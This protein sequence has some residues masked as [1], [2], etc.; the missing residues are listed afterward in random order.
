[1]HVWGLEKH[2]RGLGVRPA[3]RL[4]E[5]GWVLDV[6]VGVLEVYAGVGLLGV[7][8]VVGPRLRHDLFLAVR[9]LA[10][11]AILPARLYQKC[12]QGPAPLLQRVGPPIGRLAL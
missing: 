11:L 9:L 4:L 2:P 5:R 1:M 12:E 8:W 7:L 3:V 6:G 10:K